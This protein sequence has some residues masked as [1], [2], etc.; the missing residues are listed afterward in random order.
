MKEYLEKERKELREI[1]LFIGGLGERYRYLMLEIQFFNVRVERNTLKVMESFRD[2]G[3][4]SVFSTAG[5]QKES[6]ARESRD[7]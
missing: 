2:G 7:V 6:R 1:S 5:V 3:D 4:C